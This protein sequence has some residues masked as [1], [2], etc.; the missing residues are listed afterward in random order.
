MNKNT[1]ANITT[2]SGV[3]GMLLIAGFSI[4]VNLTILSLTT[5]SCAYLSLRGDKND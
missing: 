4:P 2:I 3:T 1:I 5:L